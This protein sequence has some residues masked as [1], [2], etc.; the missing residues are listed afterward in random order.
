[1]FINKW[2]VYMQYKILNKNNKTFSNSIQ[3]NKT[4][5]EKKKHSSKLTIKSSPSKQSI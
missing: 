2:N 5:G 1:M 4:S 3:V